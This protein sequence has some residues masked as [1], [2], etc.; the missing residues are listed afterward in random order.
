VHYREFRSSRWGKLV[1]IIPALLVAAVVVVLVA[2]GLRTL[3]AVASFVADHPGETPLRDDAPVGFPAWVGWQHFLNTFFLVFIV[4]T[5][6]VLRGKKRPPAFFTRKNTGRLRTAGSPVRI[7]IHLWLHYVVDALWVLN[8]LVFFVLLFSTGQWMRLVPTDWGV[9]PN[10]VSAGL[11]YASL[12][13]PTENGWVNYNG[14]QTLSYF[15][16]TFVAAP[17][18][19]L[20][21]I[22]L[23]PGFAARFR[24]WDAAFP[25]AAARRIHFVVMVYFVGFVIVHVT[26]VLATG[27]LRNLNHIYAGRD[28]Q[29]WWGFAV[30]AVSIAVCAAA[31][32]ALRPPVVASLAERTGTVR[33]MPS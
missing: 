27:A 21:G 33:R 17:L 14:L 19:L 31:W 6:W 20:T 23:A 9:V 25:V 7:S 12:D 18:A 5:G 16:T 15:A 4:R 2:K 29:S 30:F 3:P 28:D 32:V 11:Q 8:G 22:R 1:W 10:A 13:W 24:R 26:L